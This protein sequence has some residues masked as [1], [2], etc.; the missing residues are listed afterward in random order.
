MEAITFNTEMVLAVLER[1]DKHRTHVYEVTE[2]LSKHNDLS[3]AWEKCEKP[4]LMAWLDKHLNLFDDCV[5][6][7]MIASLI[8]NTPLVKK[9]E[10]ADPHQDRSLSYEQ[11]ETIRKSLSAWKH[12]SAVQGLYYTIWYCADVMATKLMPIYKNYPPTIVE[13]NRRTYEAGQLFEKNRAIVFRQ[14]AGILRKWNNPF[15]DSTQSVTT[16][17]DKP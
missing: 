13:G 12:E 7:D 14:Q 1:Q 11:A 10:N 2:W 3:T 5:R 9:Y 6:R 8:E 15:A 17:E 4:F 16:P